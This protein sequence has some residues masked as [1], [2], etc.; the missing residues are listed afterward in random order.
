MLSFIASVEMSQR[1]T[2]KQ[3]LFA[4]PVFKA[5]INSQSDL[6]CSPLRLLCV[7]VRLKNTKPVFVTKYYSLTCSLQNLKLNQQN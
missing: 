4:V 1:Q 7:C 5:M 2:G 6:Q 3:M